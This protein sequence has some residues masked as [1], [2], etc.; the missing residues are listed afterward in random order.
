[1]QTIK[2]V[3]IAATIVA[4][5]IIIGE[6]KADL[7]L[8]IDATDPANIVFTTTGGL[9]SANSSGVGYALWLLEFLPAPPSSGIGNFLVGDL[10][11][12]VGPNYVSASAT[13]GNTYLTA[14][15]GNNQQTFAQGQP[16]FVGQSTIDLSFLNL[17]TSD[18]IGD[19]RVRNNLNQDTGVTIG[20]YSFKAAA[21][22][23]PSS[24]L[25]MAV[26]GLVAKRL[27]RKRSV[28]E[29]RAQRLL[30][31]GQ[32]NGLNAAAG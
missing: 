31:T 17:R 13:A 1:M 6:A 18:F 7:V 5:L 30:G 27:M 10:H 25:Y 9:A 14:I 29:K 21:V 16:A 3:K 12:S 20:Q 32:N 24:F 8:S 2:S 15:L 4:T 11:P 26:T 19:I 23:E 22:P 28:G